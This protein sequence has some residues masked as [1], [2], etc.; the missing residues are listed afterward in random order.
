[1]C[2]GVCPVA[3]RRLCMLHDR[4]GEEALV[5]AH[6]RVQELSTS[7]QVLAARCRL[8]AGLEVVHSSKTRGLSEPLH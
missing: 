1:M 4:D 5:Q 3:S 8:R 7:L 6:T 2:T